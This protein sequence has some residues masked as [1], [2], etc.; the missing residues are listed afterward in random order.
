[1]SIDTFPLGTFYLYVFNSS[2]MPVVQTSHRYI[3]SIQLLLK[4]YLWKVDNNSMSAAR[5]IFIPRWKMV[6]H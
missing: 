1:M 6:N 2:N 3:E 5:T 4:Y